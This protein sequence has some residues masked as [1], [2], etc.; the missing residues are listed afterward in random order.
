MVLL[1]N[2]QSALNVHVQGTVGTF[3]V[4]KADNE[5]SGIEVKYVL[6]HVSL[7]AKQGQTQLL[8]MLA[9]VREIFDLK[10]LDFDE[11][12]QRDIDD[13]RV[14]LELIPYL[15]DPS[16]SGQIKLFPPIVAIALPLQPVSRMP[17]TLYRKVTQT[18]APS[19]QHKGFDELTITA[20]EV[21]AEQ[22]QF[23]QFVQNGEVMT[24]D[25]AMLSLSRDNC[26]LAIVD[27]QHR[28][29]ALLALHRNLT[30]G[31]TDAKRSPYERYYKVWPDKEIRTYDLEHLQMP[32][33]ICTF[34]QLDAEWQKDMDVIRAARRVFLTLNKTAK[35]VSDSRNRLLNDQ[36]IV[37]ECLRETLSHVKQFG[38]KDETGLRIF[39][40]EL[41]QE[42]DRVKVG[43]DVAFSGVSHLYHLTEH[44]LMSDDIVHGI[45]A[46]G[47]VG[48]P[49]K[50]LHMAYVRLGLKDSIVQ[51]KREAN[52]RTNY[53]DEIANEFRTK[54][55]ELYVPPIERMLSKFH[56]FAA[57]SNATLALQQELIGAHDPELEKMLFD[58][59]AT[60]RTF[61][62]FR[63]GL[64][65]RN[66]DKEPGWTSPEITETLTRVDGLVTKRKT[67]VKGMRANRANH[68]LS[69]L[70]KQ[71]L[72]KVTV[73]NII[74]E[75]IKDA[76]D[77]LFENVFSTVA[78]Q[79]ALICTYTEAVEQALGDIT[80]ST[81]E[82]LD[83]YLNSLH[84][85]FAPSNAKEL[86]RLFRVFV[87]DLSVEPT[88][89]VLTGGPVFRNV[90][91]PGELQPAEWPKYRYLLLELWTPQEPK[92]KEFVV[93]DRNT[94]RAAVA[95]SLFE[96]RF[97]SYCEENRLIHEEVQKEVRDELLTKVK[98]DFESFLSAVH[99]KNIT[100][101]RS[102][103]ES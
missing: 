52:T 8:D 65:R 21:G 64:E 75:A 58:G 59:Q 31:W 12:M 55:R 99:G 50:R 84:N 86:E 57:F 89:K 48:A 9:P 96:R 30:G 49:R 69:N 41:D 38:S 44:I 72:N 34:P 20:G 29:M 42:G 40:I 7:S 11:I 71:A 87:G 60:A 45:E 24:T 79:T 15:L 27:G 37:A 23:R 77:G 54:W 16:V 90:V 94:C 18:Q 3:R 17:D 81:T 51:A 88:V 73:D 39:N 33:I 67:L 4:T 47:K 97:K 5:A 95:A 56:P 22:F 6:T 70:S 103:F 10:Q 43:S 78:F 62:E 32:M 66:K 13:A 82:L 102:I 53:S 91:L 19:E 80:Y 101:E 92:L 36:D 74:D 25:G 76:I 35:K 2:T 63:E 61:D 1:T 100:L 93:T 46:K 26:A 98:G 83:E 85:I 28:A 14:S 68:F